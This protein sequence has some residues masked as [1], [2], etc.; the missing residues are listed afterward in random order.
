MN[1][2]ARKLISFSRDPVGA[3][4]YYGARVVDQIAEQGRRLVRPGYTRWC[5]SQLQRRRLLA[6]L[7][8][9]PATAYAPYYEDLWLLYRLV[10]KLK[11]QCVLEFGSG[12]S[13]VVMAQAIHENGSGHLYSVDAV[14]YW[15]RVTSELMPKDLR[16]VTTCSA[17]E[18]VAA[19]VGGTRT[20]RHVVVPDVVPDLIFLDGPDFQ[21]FHLGTTDAVCDPVDMER[22]FK[23]RFCM[24][25]DG[26]VENTNFLRSH[27]KR[28]YSIT[29]HWPQESWETTIFRLQ[30]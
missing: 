5:R 6:L 24:V 10:R 22:H 17:T 28:R 11:P 1:V 13:T 15:A 4:D 14:E 30:E 12:C 19:E 20:L 3:F 16:N 2:L 26:R 21:D 23:H 7:A 29:H 18:M 9:R 27:L 25:V 8:N